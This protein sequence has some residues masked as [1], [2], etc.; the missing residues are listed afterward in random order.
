MMTILS[1]GV[2]RLVHQMCKDNGTAMQCGYFL[3]KTSKWIMCTLLLIVHALFP[4]FILLFSLT[5]TSNHQA[6]KP[7][8]FAVVVSPGSFRSSYIKNHLLFPTCFFLDTPTPTSLTMATATT[9]TTTSPTSNSST[10]SKT[11]SVD[12]SDLIQILQVQLPQLHHET[13]IYAS[14]S[15]TLSPCCNTLLFFSLSPPCLA[16]PA[17]KLELLLE[18]PHIFLSIYVDDV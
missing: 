12:V 6:R 15:F 2:S 4:F 17:L 5:L 7:L 16:R 9:T 11:L 18:Q 3:F 14:I 8:F 13:I 10:C 1:S